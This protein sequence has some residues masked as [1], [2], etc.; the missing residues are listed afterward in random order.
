M[1]WHVSTRRGFSLIELLIVLV[2]IAILGALTVPRMS[3]VRLSYSLDQAAQQVESDLRR[4]QAEAIRR[5]QAIDVTRVDDSTYTI[6]SI[7]NRRLPWP[8]RFAA[9][10]SAQVQ[11]QTFG[12]PVGG[13]GAFVVSLGARRRT[14]TVNAV[15]RVSTS[16]EEAL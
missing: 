11:L 4:A 10:T 5:N 9:G 2:I 14:V 6:E 1:V 16:R 7:G 12:P 3:G 8:A 15:G 13:P